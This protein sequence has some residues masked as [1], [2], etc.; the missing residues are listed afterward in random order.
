MINILFTY[1]NL[2][3]NRNIEVNTTIYIVFLIM[4]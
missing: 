3:N 2:S 1:K 4:Y